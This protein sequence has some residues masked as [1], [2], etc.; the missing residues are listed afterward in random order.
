[1]IY[2]DKETSLK[3][4]LEY[5][6]INSYPNRY[7][8]HTKFPWKCMKCLTEIFISYKQ[9]GNNAIFCEN[10]KSEANNKDKKIKFIQHQY[11]RVVKEKQLKIIESFF[12]EIKI[13]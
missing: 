2:L 8:F 3:I 11:M 6:K 7:I 1:M 12:D 9:F 5:N 10:C 13:E 4:I